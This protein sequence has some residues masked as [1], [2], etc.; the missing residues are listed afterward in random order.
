M[1]HLRKMMLEELQRRNYSQTTVNAYL[2]IVES[3]ANYFHRSPDQLGP[4]RDPRLPG[5]PAQGKKAWRTHRR[6][7]HGRI[8]FLL[9]QDAEAGLP[10]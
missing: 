4:E 1:T 8:A 7:P 2:K 5:L 9:L 10:S 3:F 6:T